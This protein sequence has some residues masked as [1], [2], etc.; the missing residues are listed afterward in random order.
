M[1]ILSFD[2]R[3]SR[4]AFLAMIMAFLTQYGMFGQTTPYK[5]GFATFGAIG[6]PEAQRVLCSTIPIALR[7]KA[8]FIL[9]RVLSEE[10][11]VARR[12]AEFLKKV[13]SAGAV[14]GKTMRDIANIAFSTKTF[15]RN[16][17]EKTKLSDSATKS[18][19][20]ARSIVR[21]DIVALV[22]LPLQYGNDGDP[23]LP[24]VEGDPSVAAASYD[25]IV[26]GTIEYNRGFIVVRV[27]LYI[28][29]L[30][31]IV[32]SHAS[33]ASIDDT[34]YLLDDIFPKCNQ[35]ISGKPHGM[36]VISSEPSGAQIIIDGKR[37]DVSGRFVFDVEK[38]FSIAAS[39]PGYSASVVTIDGE[40]GTTTKV[41][42]VLLP[43][44]APSILI[45]SI[46]AGASVY[47]DSLFVGTTPLTLESSEAQRSIRVVAEG[48]SEFS[49]TI[50]A[51]YSGD[52]PIWLAI[53][54]EN[55]LSFESA[56]DGFYSALGWFVISL[57]CTVLSY[58]VFSQYQQTIGSV[59]AAY[60]SG[61]YSA[62]E[63][64]ALLSSYLNGYYISQ[65]FMW[66]FA[67]VSVALLGYTVF[68]FVIYLGA[69]E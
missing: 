44:T 28:V 67:G 56:K 54:S 41:H 34:A 49:S 21:S 3:L 27:Y 33:Y 13:L 63:A 59:Y 66:A 10:E 65:G 32:W 15:D 45:S 20:S 5:V 68:E 50:P 48:Y 24:A 40:L 23:L 9:T 6:V 2:G 53:P 16:F 11:Q 31:S 26:Y 64:N 43:I 30:K 52:F 18:L 42:L 38:P 60:N 22:A 7:A 1:K 57:P 55:E 8:R 36:L 25:A 51:G 17:A 47:C 62:S 29:S 61:T 58:G 35:A 14:H 12:D 37:L 69:A 4:I 19:E 39:Y 46:P